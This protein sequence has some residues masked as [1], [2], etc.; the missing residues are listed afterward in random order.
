VKNSV[1]KGIGEITIRKGTFWRG[2]GSTTH[3][4][5]IGMLDTSSKGIRCRAARDIPS[6]AGIIRSFATGTIV[7]ELVGGNC[8]YVN[9][10]WDHGVDSLVSPQEIVV[11]DS[12]LV[13]H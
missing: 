11:N 12:A 8:H 13:W 7:F 2:S 6:L 1:T 4:L 5:G 3:R 9:V 10:Y